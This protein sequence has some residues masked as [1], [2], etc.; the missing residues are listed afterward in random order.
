[1][2]AGHR[3]FD[4][5]L[6]ITART[7][8][9]PHAAMLT[10]LHE[11][12][13]E[14]GIAPQLFLPEIDGSGLEAFAQ[15]ARQADEKTFLLD[16]NGRMRLP[17]VQHLARVVFLID[18]P[19]EHMERV[20]AAP[21]GSLV[22]YVDQAHERLLAA[23]G[24]PHRR[25]FVPHGGPPPDPDPPPMD[26]RDIDLLFVGRLEH[27]P[28]IDQLRAGLE[29]NAPEIQAI[30]VA[31]AEATAGG[32]P[33]FESFLEA[34]GA[35]GVAPEDFG[36]EGLLTAL[37]LAHHWAEARGRY[38]LLTELAKAALPVTVVGEVRDDFFESTPEDLT[39]L[40]PQPFAKCL[41]LIRRARV[42]MNSVT[43][44][45]HGS[46]ERIWHGMA[47]GCAVA[48]DQ[49]S[50]MAEDF[51]DGETIMFWPRDPAA[52]APMIAD[53]ITDPQ[54]LQAMADAARPLYA[55]N[56]TWTDRAHRIDQALN[57]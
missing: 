12:F 21:E 20:M 40:G 54:R 35:W 19:L 6:L 17:E 33:V 51:T 52:I 4:K 24:V 44:F 8:N 13:R 57:G 1:M 53:A 16:I 9:H 38:L 55:A 25:V 48:T 46:H 27:P 10:G 22:T 36:L 43:V 39:L 47:A 56:H 32:R 41:E 31:T 29:G 34:C 5:A 2:S 45:P 26:T 15:A 28:G 18:H 30:V 14:I 37:D 7:E 42:L 3:S 23:L 50:F 11:G 49:S